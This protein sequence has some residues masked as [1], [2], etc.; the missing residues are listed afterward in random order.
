MKFERRVRLVAAI[1]R[2]RTW[3]QEIVSGA[4][5]G[6]QEIA[7]RHKCNPRHVEMTISL[8]FVAPVLGKAAVEG[9]LPRG[10]GVERLRD[11]SAEWSQQLA[12]LG[13]HS[14]LA[15]GDAT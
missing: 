10:I 6:T 3:L 9:R 4:A 13:L 12:K 1:A 2:G 5:S 11:A 15:E 7:K 14:D 8:A